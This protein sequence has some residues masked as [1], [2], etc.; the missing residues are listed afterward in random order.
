MAL[1]GHMNMKGKAAL[2][3]SFLLTALEDEAFIPANISIS[4]FGG[5]FIIR[6][7]FMALF[8][9]SCKVLI[10]SKSFQTGFSLFWKFEMFSYL[11][12]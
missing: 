12:L 5:F 4:I 7:M 2:V 1:Y 9:N 10:F 3:G 6:L 8:L 11:L